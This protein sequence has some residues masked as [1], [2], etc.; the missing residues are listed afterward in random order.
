MGLE[1]AL[2][3]TGAELEFQEVSGAAPL[4][5]AEPRR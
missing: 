4:S 5:V 1:L 2:R 3:L